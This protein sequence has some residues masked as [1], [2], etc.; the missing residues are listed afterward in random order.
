MFKNK[1]LSEKDR[2]EAETCYKET[3]ELLTQYKPK[4]PKENPKKSRE[5]KDN[6]DLMIDS[7]TMMPYH[8]IYG[9]YNITP[10][11]VVDLEIK[12]DKNG[13]QFYWIPK[14]KE[15]IYETESVWLRECGYA[16]NFVYVK[17]RLGLEVER[18]SN[19]SDITSR[20]DRVFKL[21]SSFSNSLAQTLDSDSSGYTSHSATS[22]SFSSSPSTRGRSSSIRSGGGGG[23]GGSSNSSIRD[24]GDDYG[25]SKDSKSSNSTAQI[26]MLHKRISKTSQDGDADESDDSDETS[27][28]SLLSEE[29]I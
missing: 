24:G 1:S 4:I 29:E 17:R 19:L 25:S 2:S 23:G 15:K 10:K 3:E 5:L 21:S 26:D 9:S 14:T 27:V 16:A 28:H 13:K 12:K 18:T 11:S 22:G 20:G 6:P 8:P 7:E